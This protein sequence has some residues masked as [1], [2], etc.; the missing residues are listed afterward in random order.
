MYVHK[1]YYL[2]DIDQFD[3]QFFGLSPREA[4]SLDPQQRLVME[5]S[6]ETGACGYCSIFS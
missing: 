3:P 5:V 6:W 1:G 2:D 4:E